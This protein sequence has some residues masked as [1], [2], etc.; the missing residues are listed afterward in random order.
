M[1]FLLTWLVYG[2]LTGSLAKWLHPGEDPVGFGATIGIGIAGSFMG[3]FISWLIGASA[4]PFN[5][6]G[7]LMGVV[8]GVICCYIYRAYRIRNFVQ[9]QGRMPKFRVK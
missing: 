6:S 7:L 5:Y 9:A 4:T 2:L 1:L 3:G 8:G